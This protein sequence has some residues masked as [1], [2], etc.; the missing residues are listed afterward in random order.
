[1]PQV[2]FDAGHFMLSARKPLKPK[3]LILWVCEKFYSI[4]LRH[5]FMSPR[6]YKKF[7][8]RWATNLEIIHKS[9]TALFLVLKSLTNIHLHKHVAVGISSAEL[10]K[11]LKRF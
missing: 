11:L 7:N 10:L 5:L 2:I 4:S 1:M 8:L 3:M 9:V 6:N